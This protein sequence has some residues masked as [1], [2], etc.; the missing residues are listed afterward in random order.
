MRVQSFV[1]FKYWSFNHQM[2]YQ[3]PNLSHTDFQK[4]LDLRVHFCNSTMYALENACTKLK[5]FDKFRT[6]HLTGYIIVRALAH[7]LGTP[8][9]CISKPSL[10]RF[11]MKGP[12]GMFGEMYCK[13]NYTIQLQNSYITLKF[14]NIKNIRKYT[15]KS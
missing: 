8:G 9:E 4:H 14:I 15:N 10:L 11:Q 5:T 6:D 12:Y 3:W 7:I 13:K 1:K 2:F